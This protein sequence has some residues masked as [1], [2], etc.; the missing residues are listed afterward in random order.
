MFIYHENTSTNENIWEKS[1][2]FGLFLLVSDYL[3]QNSV[4]FCTG[5]QQILDS[6]LIVSYVAM[7]I[8]S[9]LACGRA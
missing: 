3:Q 1:L 4:G 8:P 7:T 5:P 6:P 2:Y 9:F